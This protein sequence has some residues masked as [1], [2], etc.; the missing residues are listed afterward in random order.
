MHRIATIATVALTLALGGCLTGSGTVYD[1][2]DPYLF[3]AYAASKG[4]VPVVVVS[5]PGTG[6]RRQVEQTAIRALQAQFPGQA[7]AFQP[8][9]PAAGEGTK[10]VLMFNIGTNP[11]AQDICR[12]PTRF[13]GPVAPMS[14][15]GVVYCG[16]GPYSEAWLKT[17]APVT[18]DSPEFAAVITRLINDGVP[19]RRDPKRDIGDGPPPS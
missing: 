9:T 6:T 13:Q 5:E 11:V 8:A 19:R 12:D 17:D 1:I 16:V 10:I 7:A 4:S 2:D 18:V 3:L 15:A 14:S